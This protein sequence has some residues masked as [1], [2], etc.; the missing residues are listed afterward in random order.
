ML[1]QKQSLI[2]MFA[3]LLLLLTGK[4]LPF[5]LVSCTFLLDNYLILLTIL[6]AVLLN[7]KGPSGSSSSSTAASVYYQ[8]GLMY[9]IIASL[10]S[11]LA[12]ALT[13]KA[14]VN[15]SPRHPMFFSA[16]L[17]VYGILFLLVQNYIAFQQGKTSDFLL[18]SQIFSNWDVY[19]LIPVLANVSYLSPP[20]VLLYIALYLPMLLCGVCLF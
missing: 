13:Q 18:S 10:T 16:E 11:G 3:L 14:L 9:V 19:T 2:Q 15:S 1:G 4:L 8:Y 5:S 20:M 17:A 7:M 12:A 6:L